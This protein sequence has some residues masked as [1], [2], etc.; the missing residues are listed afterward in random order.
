[1][2]DEEIIKPVYESTKDSGF[3]G[4]TWFDAGVRNIYTTK[5]VIMEPD[6]LKGLKIRVQT[7]P[8]M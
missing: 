8:T 1:M 4:L 2:N 7:S 6:D 3:V 5:K